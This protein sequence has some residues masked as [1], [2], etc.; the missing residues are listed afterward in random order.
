L[1]SVRRDPLRQ[2][3]PSS[4]C[5]RQRGVCREWPSGFHRQDRHPG[6]PI[7][8]PVQPSFHWRRPATV[9][10]QAKLSAPMVP[11]LSH[12]MRVMA[13][14]DW[15][16][17]VSGAWHAAVP[18]GARRLTGEAARALR[19]GAHVVAFRISRWSGGSRAVLGRLIAP[20]PWAPA[21]PAATDSPSDPP[22]GSGRGCRNDSNCRWAAMP[23]S[24]SWHATVPPRSCTAPTLRS[25]PM[26][27]PTWGTRCAGSCWPSS[28]PSVFGRRR[29]L[30]DAGGD[31]KNLPRWEDAGRRHAGGR[32]RVPRPCGRPPVRR[33]RR[34]RRPPAAQGGGTGGEAVRSSPSSQRRSNAPERQGR[35]RPRLAGDAGARA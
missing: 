10:S 27:T 33:P 28:T 22:L 13:V 18:T 12:S 31:W 11:M 30:I 4:P 6:L 17:P 8:P 16:Q 24:S 35:I 15:P 3:D 19:A 23:S 26:L 14:A 2:Q 9:A 29:R 32:R 34:R 5:R 25:R 21:V 20:R 1:G 7:A